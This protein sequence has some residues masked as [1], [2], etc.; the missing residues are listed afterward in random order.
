[1]IF[2]EFINMEQEYR[3]YWNGNKTIFEIF[4]EEASISLAN[5]MV[6]VMMQQLRNFAESGR[7]F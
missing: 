5:S 4:I 1:M 7:C 6:K 2:K 3:A